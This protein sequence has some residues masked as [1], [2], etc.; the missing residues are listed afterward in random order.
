MRL[1]VAS[2][3]SAL[4]VRA[5]ET[6]DSET[7]A[8]RAMSAIVMAPGTA[9]G[10]GLAASAFFSAGLRPVLPRGALSIRPCRKSAGTAQDFCIHPGMAA[11]QARRRF[12]ELA[13]ARGGAWLDAGK[14]NANDCCNRLRDVPIIGAQ[15][16]G[17]AATNAGM[18]IPGGINS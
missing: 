11:A 15:W 7:S 13:G 8:R 12:G 3:I 1:R 18:A 9:G 5:R 14:I 2:E 6:V 10:R 4:S 17:N 16:P